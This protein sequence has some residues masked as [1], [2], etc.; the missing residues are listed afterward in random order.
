LTDKQIQALSFDSSA[1]VNDILCNFTAKVYSNTS[2]YVSGFVDLFPIRNLYLS[3]SGIGN[4]N[5][6]SVTGERSIVKQ[7]P[8]NVGFGDD[9]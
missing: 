3:C 2:P 9:L 5:M 1:T 4:F 8:V 6:M 7:I